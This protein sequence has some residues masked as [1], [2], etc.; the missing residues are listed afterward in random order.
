MVRSKKSS[1]RRRSSKS[2]R[3]R[4]KKKSIKQLR[5]ECRDKGKVYDLKTKRCRDP[6]KRGRPRKHRKSS[7]KSSRRRKSVYGGNKGDESRSR[8]DFAGWGHQ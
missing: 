1:R 2:R 8:R 4:S 3:S 7:K 5:K 6:K